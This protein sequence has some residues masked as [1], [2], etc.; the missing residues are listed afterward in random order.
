MGPPQRGTEGGRIRG[1]SRDG[2]PCP[3]RAPPSVALGLC[4]GSGVPFTF[5]LSCLFYQHPPPP[6]SIVL[7]CGAV[8]GRRIALWAVMAMVGAMIGG[9]AG[10]WGTGNDAVAATPS[11]PFMWAALRSG[12]WALSTI[13][14]GWWVAATGGPAACNAN[15]G[16]PGASSRTA[17][18]RQDLVPPTPPRRGWVAGRGMRRWRLLGCR[19]TRRVLIL[20][21]C[22]H[23]KG[24]VSDQKSE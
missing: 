15:L 5:P 6:G 13:I 19:L 20:Y 23:R 10:R 12:G 3:P 17:G 9:V 7:S 1:P 8:G 21:I 18:G 24:R 11:P 22:V 16:G 14:R 4:G 2:R